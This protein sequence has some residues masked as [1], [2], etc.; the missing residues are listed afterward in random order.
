MDRHQLYK[1]QYDLEWS[2]RAHLLSMTNFCMVAAIAIGT[3]LVAV[4]Q[5]FDY[6]SGYSLYGFVP[7]L[8]AS[9]TAWAL[10]LYYIGRT[11]IGQEYGYLP[12]AEQLEKHYANITAWT[13]MQSAAVD[14]DAEFERDLQQK[15]AAV[16]SLNFETNSR[17]TASLQRALAGIAWSLAL[18]AVAAI[19]YLLANTGGEEAI[20]SFF[21]SKSQ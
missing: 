4:A 6:A 20:V 5:S 13:K 18:L 19:P 11:L 1:E 12:K 8:L 17:K 3:A 9:V 2:H 15:I 7:L 14:P 21:T 10:S 16:A